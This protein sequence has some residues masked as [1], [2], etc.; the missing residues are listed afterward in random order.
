MAF[1]EL[2][3]I[4]QAGSEAVHSLWHS[5]TFLT[6]QPHWSHAAEVSR[7]SDDRVFFTEP[8]TAHAPSK[9]ILTQLYPLAP[10][11]ML[12]QACLP[13]PIRREKPFQPSEAQYA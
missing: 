8:S 6:P 13:A 9:G 10:R 11:E 12:R 2:R 1:A 5:Q 3:P 4:R 7:L